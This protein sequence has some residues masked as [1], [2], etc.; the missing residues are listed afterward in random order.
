MGLSSA[1]IFARGRK[2]GRVRQRPEV[3]ILRRH[4]V[5]LHHV[6]KNTFSDS[7]KTKCKL[8]NQKGRN[9]LADVSVGGKDNVEV[10]L[11]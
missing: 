7:N 1:L 10:D 3:K 9:H 8:E 4:C 2:T 5:M 11:K 6:Y